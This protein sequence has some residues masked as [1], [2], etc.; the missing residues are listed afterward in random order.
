[1]RRGVTPFEA[2]IGASSLAVA[3]VAYWLLAAPAASG[4]EAEAATR[5]ADR[6]SAAVATWR[7]ENG[8]DCPTFSQLMQEGYLDRGAST[9][10]PWGG[11]FRVVCRERRA[12]VTSPG[13]DGRL[14]TGDDL[15]VA[16]GRD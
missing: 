5:T 11:R 15:A 14:G 9:E 1:V 10:D 6:L 7:A 16:V 12:N 2:A 13:P 3:V 8:A 4:R